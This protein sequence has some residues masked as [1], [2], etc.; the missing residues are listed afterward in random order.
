MKELSI[1]VF[2]IFVGVSTISV[3]LNS[4]T[5]RSTIDALIEV[6]YVNSTNIEQ[7]LEHN[8]SLDEVRQPRLAGYNFK[9]L[10]STLP[11]E[12]S[13]NKIVYLRLYKREFVQPPS[14]LKIKISKNPKLTK[15]A[16]KNLKGN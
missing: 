13:E 16:Q 6:G 2:K 15:K 1:F 10:N 7:K 4:D 5:Y 9:Y 12:V 8:S 3:G 14:K 11:D